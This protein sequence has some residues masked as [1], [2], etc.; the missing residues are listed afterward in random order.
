MSYLELPVRLTTDPNSASDVNQLQTNMTAM[1]QGSKAFTQ[2][3]FANTSG[4]AGLHT[5]SGQ[6]KFKD[7]NVLTGSQ[8]GPTHRIFQF[9]AGAWLYP[10][11]NPAPLDQDSGTNGNEFGQLFD[12]T[13]EEFVLNKIDVPYDLNTSGTVFFRAKAYSKTAGSNQSVRLKFYHSARGK[14]ENWDNVFASAISPDNNVSATQDS[15]DFIS[16]STSAASLGWASGDEMRIKLSRIGVSSGTTV[17]GDY[18]ITNLIVRIP[19]A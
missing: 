6:L 1:L 9:P 13:T 16:W 3:N 10:T 17:S 11:A 8:G 18:S 2:I 19:R 14:G 7:E 15:Y 4:T 12:D 5:E